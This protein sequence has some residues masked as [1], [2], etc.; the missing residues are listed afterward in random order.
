MWKER[1]LRL[2]EYFKKE[3]YDVKEMS[4]LLGL[5]R[6]TMVNQLS[7]HYRDTGRIAQQ[8]STIIKTIYDN[9][10]ENLTTI[11]QNAD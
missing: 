5:N 4:E 8:D 1:T 9:V 11:T 6:R 2:I 3:G 7:Q 10:E